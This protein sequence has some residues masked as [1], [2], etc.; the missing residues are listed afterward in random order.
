[1]ETKHAQDVRKLHRMQGFPLEAA[2]R[3]DDGGQRTS[4]DPQQDVHVYSGRWRKP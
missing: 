4:D 2:C 3:D 1:M